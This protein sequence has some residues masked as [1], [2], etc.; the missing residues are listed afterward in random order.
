MMIDWLNN[1]KSSAVTIYNNNI[2]LSKQASRFFE[3]A[4]GV[5]VGI[6]T[7]TNELI[8]KKISKEEFEKDFVDSSNYHKIEI[9][10]SYGRINSKSLVARI[11]ERMNLDFS[12]QQSFKFDAKWNTGKKMLIVSTNGK[13]GIK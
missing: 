9:K 11:C 2:T 12:V 4:Y 10:T 5:S 3:D 8:I 13:K 6:D 7:D 1:D